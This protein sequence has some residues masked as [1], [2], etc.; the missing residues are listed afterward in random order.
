MYL[1][2]LGAQRN[3]ALSL[4]LVGLI[5]AGVTGTTHR[6]GNNRGNI[7]IATENPATG[8]GNNHKYDFDFIIH[9]YSPDPLVRSWFLF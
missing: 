9:Y 3:C 2:L 7:V 1:A 5:A 8:K 4:L 6:T